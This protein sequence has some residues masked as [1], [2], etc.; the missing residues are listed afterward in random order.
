M[1]EDIAHLEKKVGKLEKKKK[2]KIWSRA[3]WDTHKMIYI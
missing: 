2:I 1:T 3:A